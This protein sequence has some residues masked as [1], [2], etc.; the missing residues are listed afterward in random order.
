MH[1]TLWT[2]VVNVLTLPASAPARHA[3]CPG[4]PLHCAA[5]PLSARLSGQVAVLAGGAEAVS[6]MMVTSGGVVV[7]LSSVGC[8]VWAVWAVPRVCSL[9]EG[10]LGRRAAVHGSVSV[11]PPKDGDV[12]FNAAT[13]E[14]QQTCACA[15]EFVRHAPLFSPHVAVLRI[16]LEPSEYSVLHYAY[17]V[18]KNRFHNCDDQ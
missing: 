12:A 17:A 3:A 9:A 10:W 11:A 1:W 13:R 15:M 8:S 4:Q 14:Q 2:G 5:R 7:V 18:H 6:A 16:P